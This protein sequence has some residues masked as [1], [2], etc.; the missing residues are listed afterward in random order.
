M[1]AALV[2]MLSATDFIDNNSTPHKILKRFICLIDAIE[3]L[4]AE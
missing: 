2:L 4:I 1:D 3:E